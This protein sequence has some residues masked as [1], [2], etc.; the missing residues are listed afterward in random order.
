MKTDKETF[1]R[2]DIIDK[3]SAHAHLS[4]MMSKVE[5][6]GSY[7]FTY[8]DNFLKACND[9]FLMLL[10]KLNIETL[11]ALRNN[12][13]LEGF[14]IDIKVADNVFLSITLTRYIALFRF[15][16]ECILKYVATFV[17]EQAIMYKEIMEYIGETL[18]EKIKEQLEL[19]KKFEKEREDE[20]R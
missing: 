12:N 1:D 9:N 20:N 6:N 15:S 13:R 17:N 2:E 3:I 14:L 5:Q 16:G 11:Q 18:E 4:C 19:L 8:F 10:N 7:D